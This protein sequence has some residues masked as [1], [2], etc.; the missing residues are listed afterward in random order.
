VRLLGGIYPDLKL[1]AIV[2]ND[3]SQELG[4]PAD[5]KIEECDSLRVVLEE[6][7]FR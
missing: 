7:L 3:R 2:K 1:C 4:S 6:T 5:W